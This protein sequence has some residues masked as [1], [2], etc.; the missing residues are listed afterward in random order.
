MRSSL[1]H[2]DSTHATI[3]CFYRVYAELG[4][5]LPEHHY[6]AALALELSDTGID[7]RREYPID[8]RYLGR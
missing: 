6:A 2:E 4:Y 5:G 3:G 7:V 1:L 8:V